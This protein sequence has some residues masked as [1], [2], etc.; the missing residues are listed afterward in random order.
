[1]SVTNKETFEEW[2]NR[3]KNNL[4]YDPMVSGE[5]DNPRFRLPD[6]AMVLALIFLVLLCWSM[7]F[8]IKGNSC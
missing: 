7:S 3:N 1:M 2:Y 8:V 5:P 4:P 6:S